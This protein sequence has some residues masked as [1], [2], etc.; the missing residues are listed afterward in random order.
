MRI[1]Q[2]E[3]V[4]LA[5]DFKAAPARPG[6]A[7]NARHVEVDRRALQEQAV[8]GMGENEDM[9]VVQRPQHAV[10]LFVAWKTEI[11]MNG[12]DDQIEPGKEVVF[13][14]EPPVRQNIDLR[15]PEHG[16]A[17]I[18]LVE[19]VDRVDLREKP[20]PV[21][22]MRDPHP[23]GM[24]GDGEHSPGRAPGRPGPSRSGSSRRR[25]RWCAHAGRP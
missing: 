22:T 3:A 24:V 16:E 7:Q 14:N 2:I 6:G 23:P 20:F 4:G 12:G 9:A 17:R 5:I 10:R 18:L 1:V 25:W 8:G 13:E 21:E 15:A 19:A 11:G